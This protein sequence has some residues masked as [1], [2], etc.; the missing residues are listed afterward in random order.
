MK[1]KY[2]SNNGQFEVEFEGK[3]QKE[4]FAQIA[5]WQEVFEQ[6]YKDS[7]GPYKFVSRT[8]DDNVFYELHHLGNPHKVLQFG[9]HKKGGTLFPKRVDDEKK[10]IGE[11]GWDDP[12]WKKN[13][14]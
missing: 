2:K 13:K 1:V 4:L 6:Q 11:Q 10:T 5:E 3:D 9:C 7:K 12:F 14:Q 8:V